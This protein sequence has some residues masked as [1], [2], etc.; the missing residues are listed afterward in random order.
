[1]NRNDPQL[2]YQYKYMF[3][4]SEWAKHLAFGVPVKAASSNGIVM[5]LFRHAFGGPYNFICEGQ[6][7]CEH[8]KHFSKSADSAR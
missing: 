5:R 4:I 7:K 6:L 3:N 8:R 2:K 1:M